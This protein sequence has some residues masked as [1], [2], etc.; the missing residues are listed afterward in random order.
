[1]SHFPYS[2]SKRSRN[3]RKSRSKVLK[4]INQRTKDIAI[5]LADV[6]ACVDNLCVDG[7]PIISTKSSGTPK[8]K[9]VL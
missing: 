9:V 7:T 8:F 1:M 6:K 4:E 2:L 5:D 3:K